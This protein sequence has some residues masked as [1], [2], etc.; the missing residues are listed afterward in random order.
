ML[1][2]CKIDTPES[3]LTKSKERVVNYKKYAT[4]SHIRYNVA[5]RNKMKTGS[6]LTKVC[7][8]AYNRVL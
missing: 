7:L 1:L 3:K 4:L 6:K 8:R 2:K 5:N